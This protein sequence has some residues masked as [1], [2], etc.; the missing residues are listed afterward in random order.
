[1]HQTTWC[2]EK[3]IQFIEKNKDKNWC[4]TVNPFAPHPTFH[5]PKE[6]LKDHN[7]LPYPIFKDTDIEHQLK[8][9]EIDQ[10]SKDSVNPYEHDGKFDQEN[11][12]LPWGVRASIPPKN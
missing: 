8:F 7:N 3:S 4:L 12:E 5:P 11:A 1:M 6:Y 9:K 10:Q 2:T